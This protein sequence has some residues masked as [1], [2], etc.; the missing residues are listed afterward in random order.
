MRYIRLINAS[1]YHR[2]ML[3][4]VSWASMMHFPSIQPRYGSRASFGLT[5][6]GLA[7]SADEVR[8]GRF[9]LVKDGTTASTVGNSIKL[10]YM[11]VYAVGLVAPVID[12]DGNF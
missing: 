1:M 5:S 6:G 9:L 7:G 8:S 11:P 4:R 2:P 3:G 12:H 10:H